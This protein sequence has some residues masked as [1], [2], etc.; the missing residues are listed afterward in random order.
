[1]FFLSQIS[2]VSA[3]PMSRKLV[4]DLICMVIFFPLERFCW[5]VW[6][7]SKACC[8]RLDL[9]NILLL[10]GKRF[11]GWCDFCKA[12]PWKAHLSAVLYGFARFLK[13]ACVHHDVVIWKAHL[14]CGFVSVVSE[15]SIGTC[16][17]IRH[18]IFHCIFCW[19]KDSKIHWF[20]EQQVL[21]LGMMKLPTNNLVG[22]LWQ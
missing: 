8:L 22:H 13:L 16:V 11:V 14:W 4:W 1:V 19:F 18:C 10:H 5:L 6:L 9:C 7:L 20:N 12:T 2:S 17:L 15:T 21:Q 3:H